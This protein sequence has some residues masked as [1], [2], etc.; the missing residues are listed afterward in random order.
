MKKGH[1]DFV[2]VLVNLET[3]ELVDILPERSKAYLQSYFEARGAVFCQQLEVFC[4]DM[5]EG[6]IKLAEE[7]FPNATIVV[8]RFHF[9]AYV[10]KA[11]DS[12][13]KYL[14]RKFDDS[15]LLKRAKWPLLK[16]K[17]TLSDAEKE[18]LEQIFQCEEFGLLKLAYEAKNKF[19]DIF[20]SQLTME[21]AE[22]KL[23]QW[24]KD[25]ENLKVRHLFPFL[26]TIGK[27][28]KYMLAYF[29][30]RYTTSPVEGINNKIKTIKR[31]AFGYL[32]FDNFRRK[33]L[34]D[35]LK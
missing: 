19:R 16:N 7:I 5:W 13:R 10:Q 8:D 17:E 20:Q 1:K 11:L 9:F 34:I 12:C 33:A 3:H 31:R 24:V 4:S 18:K 25:V 27:W 32:N 22:I 35:F 30:Q 6:Y 14:R 21:E 15:E 28:K 29:E 23:E 2:C 26:K